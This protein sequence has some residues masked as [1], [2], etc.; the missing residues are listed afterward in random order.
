MKGVGSQAARLTRAKAYEAT[1]T[2]LWTW[3]IEVVR[4]RGEQELERLAKAKQEQVMHSRHIM[5]SF[6]ELI[7]SVLLLQEAF[8]QSELQCSRA[9]IISFEDVVKKLGGLRRP[10]S[11]RPEEAWCLL[12][13]MCS[14]ADKMEHASTVDE[15]K[16]AL[17]TRT[18]ELQV[19]RLATSGPSTVA[20]RDTDLVLQAMREEASSLRAMVDTQREQATVVPRA[21]TVQERVMASGQVWCLVRYAL[22]R[23]PRGH[24]SRSLSGS[25]LLQ[26]AAG[27]ESAGLAIAGRGRIA[28]C[29]DGVAPSGRRRPLD[30]GEH[31]GRMSV[32]SLTPISGSRV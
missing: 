2:C 12:F 32:H 10:G 16:R 18:K 23:A 24:P 11:R 15:L 21:F 28:A 13:F 25:Q 17:S 27:Q 6:L 7:C 30:G 29:G 9:Q 5:G 26:A 3:R 1:R 31:G 8:L 22:S 4:R 20:K 19:R 14:E